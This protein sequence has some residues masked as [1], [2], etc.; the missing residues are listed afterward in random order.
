MATEFITTV[1]AKQRSVILDR[2]ARIAEKCFEFGN[3][4][5][6]QEI[7][8]GLDH[9]GV[10]KVMS[11]HQATHSPVYTQLQKAMENYQE[12]LNERLRTG[13]YA[14]PVL[15]VYLKRMDELAKLPA[16]DPERPDNVLFEKMHGLGRIVCEIS[17]LQSVPFQKVEDESPNDKTLKMYLMTLDAR[18]KS[19][20]EIDAA[21][22]QEESND[23][24]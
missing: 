15:R 20:R 1:N 9:A 10:A 4:Q 23:I 5:C 12:H 14:I 24:V 17:A 3:F 13:K 11:H 16:T 21:A 8:S 22:R 19:D 2:F 6:C 18:V 7:L